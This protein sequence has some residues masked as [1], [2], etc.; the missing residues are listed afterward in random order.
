VNATNTQ[1]GSEVH[2]AISE[3]FNAVLSALERARIASTRLDADFLKDWG[4][5]DRQIERTKE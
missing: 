3:P 2:S 5:I 4:N 1:L